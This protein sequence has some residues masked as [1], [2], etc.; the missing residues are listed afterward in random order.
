[1]TNIKTLTLFQ[2]VIRG[3]FPVQKHSQNLEIR[4][5]A[6]GLFLWTDVESDEQTN[7]PFI[8]W[9]AHDFTDFRPLVQNILFNPFDE[10]L[11]GESIETPTPRQHECQGRNRIG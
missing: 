5:Q 10:A 1:M 11:L 2:N 4:N 7:C 6:G 3:R 9:E 8:C